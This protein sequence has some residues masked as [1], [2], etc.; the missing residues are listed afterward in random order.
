MAPKGVLEQVE[1]DLHNCMLILSQLLDSKEA[2][3]DKMTRFFNQGVA[4]FGH[5]F[6][7]GG[8]NGLKAS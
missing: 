1:E 2:R 7:F 5:V 6:C 4:W 8:I 3:L